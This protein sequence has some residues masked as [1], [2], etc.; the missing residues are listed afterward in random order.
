MKQLFKELL[1]PL[2]C[3]CIIISIVFFGTVQL[4]ETIILMLKN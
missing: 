3:G 4:F 2:F 1:A